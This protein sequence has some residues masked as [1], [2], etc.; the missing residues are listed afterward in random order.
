MS[1]SKAVGFVVY[2]TK[3]AKLAQNFPATHVASLPT[4]VS[5]PEQ[6]GPA[7]EDLRVRR[8]R[9]LIQQAMVE[10]VVEKGFS[11]ITVQDI[12][13]RAMVNRSTFYRH[14]L[15]KYD[16][17]EKYMDEVYDMV[18]DE[19]FLADKLGKGDGKHTGLITLLNHIRKNAAFYQVMLGPKGDPIVPNRLRTNTMRRFQKLLSLAPPD[20]DPNAPPVELRI[21]YIAHAG[22]G[23]IRWWMDHLDECSAEQLAGWLARL[24]SAAAGL[25]FDEFLRIANSVDSIDY[26]GR[27]S[28]P[29][30]DS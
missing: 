27:S 2:A 7:T 10:L 21:S 8:T 24:S 30:A 12:A 18:S 26:I 29:H 19:E 22:V 9:K 15:D 4:K 13:D 3:E 25:S 11:T 5:P 17:L 23:A 6:P 1:I 28:P 20:P 16:L 14:Y